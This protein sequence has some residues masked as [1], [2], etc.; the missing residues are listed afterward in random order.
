[1]DIKYYL[2]NKKYLIKT[3][4]TIIKLAF[5]PCCLLS[6]ISITMQLYIDEDTL[7]TLEMVKGILYSFQ[8]WGIE[9][10]FITI[11]IFFLYKELWKDRKFHKDIAILAIFFSVFKFLG[12]CYAVENGGIYLAFLKRNIINVFIMIIGFSCL[13]YHIMKALWLL[14]KSYLQK[15]VFEMA[16]E[17]KKIRIVKIIFMCWLPYFLLLYPGT[18]Q[19]DTGTQLNQFFGYQELTNASPFLQTFFIGV[20]VLA[21]A[22]IGSASLGIAL[23]LLIQMFYMAAVIAYGIGVMMAKGADT[24]ICKFMIALFSFNPI[25]PLYAISVGK[26]INFGTTVLLFTVIICEIVHTEG[27]WLNESKKHIILLYICLTL[28]SLLRN[29][30]FFL[31]VSCFPFLLWIV[32]ENKKVLTV[33]YVDMVIGLLVWFKVLLP[34]YGVGNNEIIENLSIPLQ[35]T[36]RYVFYYEDEITDE[37]KRD[38]DKMLDYSKISDAYNPEIVD[39]IKELYRDN[40]TTADIKKYMH[41]YFRQMLKHPICYL[42]AI[43]NKSNGYFY[44]N[45]RGREKR[46]AFVGLHN[47]K[48]FN[49]QSGLNICS[50]FPRLVNTFQEFIESDVLREIPFIGMFFSIGFY[51]WAFMICVLFVKKANKKKYW[52]AFLP[53]FFVLAGCI[54]SPCN[55]YFRYAFPIVVCMPFTVLLVFMK[56]REITNTESTGRFMQRN[57]LNTL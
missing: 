12:E 14:R 48:V 8:G 42:D 4:K 20:F 50:A 37:E 11:G 23:Y 25:Y 16:W 26:D 17:E 28:I 22:K 10:Y 34:C 6:I 51:T 19:W 54:G 2:N 57:V 15:R 30:G 53:G 7:G 47:I 18:I 38:I 3:K 1:M 52:I 5:Y 35:Q 39:P 43:F 27:A 29:A 56:D 40:V 41:I 45:D 36:A 44:P 9:N 21:G 13:S 46:Y 49:E 32:K 55:A 33:I 31:A 24:K